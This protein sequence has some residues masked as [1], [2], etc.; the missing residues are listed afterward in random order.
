MLRANV[1]WHRTLATDLALLLAA[2]L[3][4]TAIAGPPSAFA[5]YENTLLRWL[6]FSI[7]WLLYCS[8]RELSSVAGLPTRAHGLALLA[9]VLAGAAVR[10][11]LKPAPYH[12]FNWMNDLVGRVA[13]E[14]EPAWYAN[15]Y[16]IFMWPF[17]LAGL[18]PEQAIFTG[19][20]VCGLLAPVALYAATRALTDAPAT[21]LWAALLL[22]VAPLHARLSASESMQIIPAFFLL[23][24][25]VGF[26]GH[27]RTGSRSLLAVGIGAFTYAVLTRADAA[28]VALALPL[29]YGPPTDRPR[30][31]DPWLWAGTLAACVLAGPLVVKGLY[32]DNATLVAPSRIVRTFLE[33]LRLAGPPLGV[34]ALAAIPGLCVIAA[35]GAAWG[36]GAVL[37]ALVATASVAGFETNAA[38]RLQLLCAE[39]P[40]LLIGTAALPAAIAG[41]AGHVQQRLGIV[42][43]ACL[44]VIVLAQSWRGHFWHV[45]WDQHEEWAFFDHALPLVNQ[46]GIRTVVEPSRDD[47]AKTYVP[48]LPVYRLG[49]DSPGSLSGLLAGRIRPPA[50]YYRS[51]ACF[52]PPGPSGLDTGAAIDGIRAC[53]DVESRFVLDPIATARIDAPPFWMTS[54]KEP[55][56]IGFF[57]VVAKR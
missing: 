11:A 33:S 52:E 26:R 28:V 51:L 21:A 38:N 3:A 14:P 53:K 54:R 50:I 47:V 48:S 41:W 39:L 20:R 49:I 34:W 36:A 24:S 7:P 31:R 2:A 37:T 22:A 13:S 57:R 8:R 17:T 23:L 35:G 44:A 6:L 55:A 16:G 32:N 45:V 15:G 18:D 4:C 43:T 56:E 27:A 42:A 46:T 12:A 30:G 25:V 40:W 5:L 10:F 9:I 1:R 19:N 29:L